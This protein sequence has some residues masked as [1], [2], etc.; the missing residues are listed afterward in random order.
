MS[1]DDDNYGPGT[2]E[3]TS[4]IIFLYRAIT[5]G[6]SNDWSRVNNSQ[7]RK[8]DD[9]NLA[10]LANVAG[11]FEKKSINVTDE[12][13]GDGLKYIDV[14]NRVKDSDVRGA[15]A[16]AG[17]WDQISRTIEKARDDF[18]TFIANGDLGWRGASKDAAVAS[19]RAALND[20]NSLQKSAEVMSKIVEKYAHTADETKSQ[21]VDVYPDYKHDVIDRANSEYSAHVD[22]AEHDYD[23]YA[24]TVMNDPYRAGVN[25]VKDNVP[26][27]ATYGNANAPKPF[28]A[29]ATTPGATSP[30]SPSSK[31]TGGSA[32]PTS[33]DPK[34]LVPDKK[35]ASTN[36]P[37]NQ[38]TNSAQ[39]A[40]Q[41]ATQGASDAAKGATDA[42][43]SAADSAK[44]ALD[45]GLQSLSSLGDLANSNNSLPEGALGLGPIGAKTADALKSLGGRTG[46]GAGGGR[47]TST[48]APGMRPSATPIE[49]TK[50][51]ATQQSAT[52]SRAGIGASG[53]AGGGGAPAAGARGAGADGKEHKSNKALRRVQNELFNDA[54]AVVSVLGAAEEKPNKDTS[55]D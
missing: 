48:S 34:S 27:V 39:Q 50:T 24:Q 1:G 25:G 49:A 8:I 12:V 7:V 45:Q 28:Q 10:S 41:Q 6:S 9:P 44:N 26:N 22:E 35:T 21:I 55:K 15:H 2:K 31:S 42:A 19:A 18:S 37:T 38:S 51:A 3:G 11:N 14:Y 47:G 46:G 53:A 40:A 29:P 5:G 33:V 17:K 16:D 20:L 32:K 36:T 52:T 23:S 4:G 54:E 43:K 30:S 13:F